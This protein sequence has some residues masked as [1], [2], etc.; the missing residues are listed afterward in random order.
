[1]DAFK[2]QFILYFLFEALLKWLIK[3]HKRE[4]KDMK[5]EVHFT[6]T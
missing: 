5:Q 1:M 2:L 6:A 4:Y 3:I